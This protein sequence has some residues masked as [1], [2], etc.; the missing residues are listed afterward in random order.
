MAGSD[1][2]SKQKVERFEPGIEN[3]RSAMEAQAAL[4]DELRDQVAPT[5][6][7][8]GFVMYASAASN[9]AIRNGMVFD[10]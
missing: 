4:F 3:P 10:G 5:D 9:P 7:C 2:G 8:L 1:F 6:P